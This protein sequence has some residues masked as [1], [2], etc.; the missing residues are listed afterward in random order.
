M[1]GSESMAE[2]L[3]QPIKRA[4]GRVLLNARVDEILIENG[5]AVGV[6]MQDDTAVRVRCGVV[7]STSRGVTYG[8]L[9]SREVCAQY[10]VKVDKEDGFPLTQSAG[11]IMVNVGI[12]GKASDLGITNLNLWY[13]PADTNDD[14]IAPLQRLVLVVDGV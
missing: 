11:F 13:H 9:I 8:Q 1:G 5:R 10:G 7:S 2:A 14:I 6:R 4:G 12:K 3:V